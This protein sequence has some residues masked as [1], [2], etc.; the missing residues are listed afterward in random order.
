MNRNAMV[1]GRV[2]RGL[3][4]SGES[5]RRHRSRRT[6]FAP[7]LPLITMQAMHD[8]EIRGNRSGFVAWRRAGAARA[9]FTMSRPCSLPE[10]HDT[11]STAA[12]LA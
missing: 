4:V 12:L 2:K 7:R 10:R 3:R 6:L 11:P 9:A 5:G 1:P 8:S